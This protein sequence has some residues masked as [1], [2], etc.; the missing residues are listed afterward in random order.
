MAD[1]SDQRIDAD[2]ALGTVAGAE[3][4]F[5]LV[6]A[7]G[8]SPLGQ[9][10]YASWADLSN[11][12]SDIYVA[13]SLDGGTTWEDAV[14]LTDTLANAAVKPFLVVSP[15]SPDTVHVVYQSVSGGVRDIRT[16]NSS[17]NGATFTAPSAALDG[18]DDSFHP[19]SYTHLTLPTSDL[20]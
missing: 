15:G 18:S 10:I 17:D 1:A 7:A 11:G 2:G 14:N 19:V 9:R 6:I 8:G 20:V 5:D 16:Q 4:S 3:H 13:H 12:N